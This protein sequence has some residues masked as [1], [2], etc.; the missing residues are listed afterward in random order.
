MELYYKVSK[1]SKTGK[2]F[3][4]IIE[5]ID[6]FHEKAKL[7]CEKYGIQEIDVHGGTNN[8]ICGIYACH[9]LNTPNN[10][11]WKKVGEGYMPKL[12]SKNNELIQD[13]IELKRLSVERLEM[14]NL[15]G[16]SIVGISV[17]NNYL[18]VST[19]CNTKH[20]DVKRISLNEIT[21]LMTK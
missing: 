1:D 21:R 16:C 6:K 19:N 11:D 8:V 17:L 20:S 18:I 15:I 13:F 3:L 10:S 14:D 5:R 4:A 2:A 9:F 7:V 12:R